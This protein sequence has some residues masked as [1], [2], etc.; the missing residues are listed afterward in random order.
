MVDD[1]AT[2]QLAHSF[3]PFGEELEKYGESE[4][5]FG[6]AGQQFDAQT[7]LLYL[8]ARYYAP[9]SGR[10]INR[11]TWAGDSNMPM[12]YNA[13]LYGYGNPVRYVDPSGKIPNLADIKDGN[14]IY[15]DYCGFLDLGHLNAGLV[16]NLL[17]QLADEN[18]SYSDSENYHEVRIDTTV[19][20]VNKENSSIYAIVKKGLDKSTRLSVA[21]GIF[22]S[23]NEKI[24]DNQVWFTRYS[25]EDLSSDQIGFYLGANFGNVDIRKDN[26]DGR[27]N[28]E[29]RKRLSDI[30]GFPID[31]EDAKERTIEVY[32]DFVKGKWLFFSPIR[33]DAWGKYLQPCGEEGNDYKIKDLPEEFTSISPI[34]PSRNGMWWIYD[35]NI[36]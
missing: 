16:D 18:K 13:W 19:K 7:G 20:L 5:T 28:E 8:R 29:A 12:S 24:E 6:Y 26:S 31:K 32:N 25:F 4:A 21:L 30:C 36:D 27:P 23:L 15:C 2:L 35:K 3:T 22:Q 11:D 14:I 1:E 17:N 34:L 33:I 10:F 9:G